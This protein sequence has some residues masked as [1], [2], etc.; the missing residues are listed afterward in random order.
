MSVSR[1][2]FVKTSAVLLPVLSLNPKNIF[3][4]PKLFK[5]V[6]PGDALWPDETK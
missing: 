2:K 4:T 5:R 6:R 1:R 3:A